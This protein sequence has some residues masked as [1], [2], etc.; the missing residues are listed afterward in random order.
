[1]KNRLL[2][3]YAANLLLKEKVLPKAANNITA[4]SAHQKKNPIPDGCGTDYSSVSGGEKFF[5]AAV[6][7]W[8]SVFAWFEPID[9]GAACRLFGFAVPACCTAFF[10]LFPGCGSK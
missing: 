3:K 6:C 5:A 8:S 9:V 10:H 1:M 4:S 2:V 7:G